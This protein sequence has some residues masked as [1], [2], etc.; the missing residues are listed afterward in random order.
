MQGI[1]THSE[2]AAE[3]IGIEINRMCF[4]EQSKAYRLF[5]KAKKKLI[6]SRDVVFIEQKV[7][8][9]NIVTNKSVLSPKVN[10]MKQRNRSQQNN[11]AT[12][13]RSENN[14]DDSD[15]EDETDDKSNDDDSNNVD[16]DIDL[17][18]TQDMNSTSNDSVLICEQSTI[19]AI[20]ATGDN[21][22]DTSHDEFSE[23]N[24]NFGN[25]NSSC[26][27]LNETDFEV[28]ASEMA[29]IDEKPFDDD[30]KENN[31]EALGLYAML[32]S[33]TIDGN[34]PKTFQQAM[35]C[36]DKVQWEKAIPTGKQEVGVV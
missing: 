36:S 2:A 4:R 6:V 19:D 16:I 21:A 5:N 33:A 10:A 25:V 15:S 23:A 17:T 22:N 8:D 14:D 1:I 32:A 28:A 24:G 20:N 30:R 29:T 12:I 9:N 7:S 31:R 11:K 3:Q 34:E 18:V 26:L 27:S 13:S 35:N